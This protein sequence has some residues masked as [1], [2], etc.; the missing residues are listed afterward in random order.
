MTKEPSMPLPPIKVE[1]GRDPSRSAEEIQVKVTKVRKPLGGNVGG[2]SG[3]T[4]VNNKSSKKKSTSLSS[5]PAKVNYGDDF[6]ESDVQLLMDEDGRQSNNLDDEDDDFT[7]SM[8]RSNKKRRILSGNGSTDITSSGTT[9]P[10]AKYRKLVISVS[11]DDEDND[12][13]DHFVDAVDG[14]LVGVNDDNIGSR[15]NHAG[16]IQEIAD[17]DDDFD[18]FE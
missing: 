7:P 1:F 8:N 11:D 6:S 10:S 13:N 9:A 3:G 2:S 17:D 4:G 16:Y 5:L 14:E 12:S 15:R 18:D